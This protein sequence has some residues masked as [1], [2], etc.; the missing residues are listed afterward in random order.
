MT[1]IREI[2]LRPNI[3]ERNLNLKT[4]TTRKL[5]DIHD[6]V[7]VVVLFRGHE[8]TSQ[9]SYIEGRSVLTRMIKTLSEI[10][11][12]EREPKLDGRRLTMVLTKKKKAPD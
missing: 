9:R 6:G 3:D 12:V 2:R 1:K 7:I 5:L 4:E 10:A 8:I 11:S